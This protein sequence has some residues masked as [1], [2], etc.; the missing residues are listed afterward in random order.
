MTFTGS[1]KDASPNRLDAVVWGLAELSN[2]ASYCIGTDEEEEHK[3]EPD[4]MQNADV[5]NE[6]AWE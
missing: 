5:D 3:D 1:A 4:A 2:G 6:E